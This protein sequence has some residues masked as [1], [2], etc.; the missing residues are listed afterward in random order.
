M[1]NAGK[2]LRVFRREQTAERRARARSLGLCVL[3]CNR[4]A[5]PGGS[6]C[7]PCRAKKRAKKAASA[8]SA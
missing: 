5:E 3:L 8:P 4:P 1:A 2:S 6:T 7:E